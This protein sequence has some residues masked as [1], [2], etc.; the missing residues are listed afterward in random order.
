[1]SVLLL[2]IAVAVEVLW[3]LSLLISFG[4]SS[5]RRE[6][7][8][9]DAAA[10]AAIRPA[11]EEALAIYLAGGNNIGDLKELAR[12]N[13]AQT[14]RSILA[15]QALAGGGGSER[16]GELVLELALAH[17]WVAAAKSRDLRKQCQGF[18]K[19]YSVANYEPVMRIADDAVRLALEHRDERVRLAAARVL[20][21]SPEIGDAAKAFRLAVSGSRRLRAL[22]SA[23]LRASAFSL[24]ETVIPDLLNSQDSGLTVRVLEMIT[25]WRSALPLES[26]EKLS[27]SQDPT[28]RLRTMELLPMLPTTPQN[29]NAIL[30]CLCDPD[31]DVRAA[32]EKGARFLNVQFPG[33]SSKPGPV[34]APCAG[35]ACTGVLA[36][37]ASSGIVEG[38]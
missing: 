9:K 11:I 8:R 3:G 33:S 17:D 38:L 35:N 24:C 31:A 18:S 30:R 1:M 37:G 26:V 7:H 5:F 36:A 25:P 29:R 16:I 4:V 6:M 13:R 22:L 2:V 32:A 19:I 12:Q 15:F 23:D 10:A 27:E 21:R 28:V 20:A 34:D 14:E